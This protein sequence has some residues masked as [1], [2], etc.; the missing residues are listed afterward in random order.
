MEDNEL[1]DVLLTNEKVINNKW[2]ESTVTII[3]EDM[4]RP[5][6]IIGSAAFAGMSN[7]I[8]V[9]IPSTILE[10]RD[11]AFSECNNLKTV[12]IGSNVT[13]IGSQAFRNC[14]SLKSIT[15]P[16]NVGYIGESIFQGCTSLTSVTLSNVLEAIP[17]YA[18]DGCSSLASISIP[19]SVIVFHDG[20]F[21]GCAFTT[22]TIPTT[23]TYIGDEVFANCSELVTVTTYD[24]L[25]HIGT[26]AFSGCDSLNTISGIQY[27]GKYAVKVLDKELSSY[28]LG[29]GTRWIGDN[30]FEDCT[31][32]ESFIIPD[33]V[34]QVGKSA[35]HNCTKLSSITFGSGLKTIG[36]C[37]FQN[38]VSLPNIV[39]PGNVLTIGDY[40]FLGCTE[41]RYVTI[42]NGCLDVGYSAFSHCISYSETAN[43][44]NINKYKAKAISDD[45]LCYADGIKN[46]GYAT[47]DGIHVI[48]GTDNIK[49]ISGVSSGSYDIDDVNI[50]FH[51]SSFTAKET[52]VTIVEGENTHTLYVYNNSGS[53]SVSGDVEW[54]KVRWLVPEVVSVASSNDDGKVTIPST[55]R[56]IGDLAFEGCYKLTTFVVDNNNNQYSVYNNSLYDKTQTE[57][58]CC[59]IT[60]TGVYTLP[61]TV[62]L[63]DKFAFSRCSKLTR[64]DI[65]SGITTIHMHAFAGC[66][67]LDDLKIGSTTYPKKT[68]SGGSVSNAYK[69]MP[70][71]MTCHN[72]TYTQGSTYNYDDYDPDTSPELC[73]KGFH[74]CLRLCDV[75]NYYGGV[76]APTPT[77]GNKFKFMVRKVNLDGISSTTNKDD[78]KVVAEEIYI[79]SRIL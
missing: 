42:G 26:N 14:T 60:K 17:M 64:V 19:S 41:V 35:F 47:A 74:A 5:Y 23:V 61:N 76:I 59:P 52:E 24:T 38:C 63:I 32:L 39:I 75:F 22:F 77:D 49:S 71:D 4:L 28:S 36:A 68:V 40:A 8:S 57:I 6:Q 45:G 3:T 67:L 30:L 9:Q 18:F 7:I 11:G 10:I 51:L 2:N 62:K 20:A 33:T 58:I 78:S 29:T 65:P 44:S 54:D 48:V 1:D 53:G 50:I 21:R 31:N 66:T 79:G 25:E 56:N 46:P 73:N 12:S 27:A 13:T 34:I 37:A 55:V 43:Q 72:F 16:N 15:I 70:G 69:A